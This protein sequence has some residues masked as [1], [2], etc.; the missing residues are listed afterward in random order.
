[1]ID[2]KQTLRELVEKGGSDLHLKVDASPL[3]R[4]DGVLSPDDREPALAAADTEGAL[5]ELLRD[6][7]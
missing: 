1:M 2:V 6:V 3:Y 4:V 7:A 5:R